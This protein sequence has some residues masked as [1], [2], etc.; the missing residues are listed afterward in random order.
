MS[1][2]IAP[3]VGTFMGWIAGWLMAKGKIVEQVPVCQMFGVAPKCFLRFWIAG[4]ALWSVVLR[5]VLDEDHPPCGSRNL[6]LIR[7]AGIAHTDLSGSSS[8]G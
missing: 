5:Q 1:Q 7:N 2:S 4:P 8:V 6:S 3:A